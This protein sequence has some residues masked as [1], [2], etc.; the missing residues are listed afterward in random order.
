[1][2]AFLDLQHLQSFLISVVRL[3]LWLALLVALFAPLEAL[4]SVQSRRFF[5]KRLWH[6][7]GYYFVSGLVPGL[8]L[9]LPIAVVAVAAHAIVPDAWQAT[10]A[11]LPLWLRVVIGFV[12]GEIGFYWGHRWAHEIP[13]LWRFHAIH[14]SA[15]EIYFLISSRAHPVDSVFIR[16]CGLVPAYLLGVA[17]PLTPTGSLVPVLIVIVATAWGFFIHSNLRW[18]LGPLEWIVA[19]PRFHHWHHTLDGLR[20]RNYASMLPWIDR[21][22]GTHHLPA[23]AWPTHYGIDEALPASLGGQLLHPLRRTPR[24][25]SIAVQPTTDDRHPA[26]QG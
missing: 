2:S 12:V 9:A 13:L 25:A 18:R 8:L 24:T 22:F 15:E 26:T 16:L 23:G 1:M 20:N 7:L 14:H 3:G 11:A 19:T 10:V 4:F 5:S 6:D 21:L 17:S